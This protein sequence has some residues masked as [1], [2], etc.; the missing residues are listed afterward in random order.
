MEQMETTSTT[1]KIEIIWYFENRKCQRIGFGI[2]KQLN[3][4]QTQYDFLKRAEN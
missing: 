2:V 1:N 3:S 4:D